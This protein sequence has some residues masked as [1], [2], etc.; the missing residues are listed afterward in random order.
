MARLRAGVLISGRGSN[1]KAL[2]DACGDRTFPSE[3]VAVISNNKDAAGLAYARQAG[4]A[5]GILDPADFADRA[6][7]DAALHTSLTAAGIELLCLAGYMRLLTRD[8]LA[9]WHD[10]VINIH[11]SLL[12][13]FRGLNAHAQA[14]ASGVKLSG[15]TVHVVRPEVDAGPIIVQAAVPVLPGDTPDSLAARVLVAEHRIYPLALQLFGE[16]RV[17]I[18]GDQAIVS[19]KGDGGAMLIQPPG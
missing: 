11:P 5:T 9:Q 1:L 13:A 3:I 6:T 16:G 2:L 7:F 12:P 14:L 10:R 4:V 17:H 8:F 19:G 15:C 18:E